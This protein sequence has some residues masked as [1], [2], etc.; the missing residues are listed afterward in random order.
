MYLLHVRWKMPP[1]VRMINLTKKFANLVTV[2][3]LNLEIREREI[4]GLL[5]PNGTRKTTAIKSA[6]STAFI[7]TY[8]VAHDQDKVRTQIGSAFQD[9]NWNGMK[10]ACVHAI[11]FLGVLGWQ[12]NR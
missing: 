6:E 1:I 10:R 7:G 4:L 8:D 12:K 5:G 11:G 3:R 9:L 2:D